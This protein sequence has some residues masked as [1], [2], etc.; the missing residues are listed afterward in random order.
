M[1][2]RKNYKKSNI[3]KISKVYLYYKKVEKLKKIQ[4]KMS[5]V[6]KYKWINNNNY[7]KMVV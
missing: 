2:Y 1:T 6:I 3:N 7:Y 4:I 5:Q